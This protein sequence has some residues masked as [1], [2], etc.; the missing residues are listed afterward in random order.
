M[1]IARN[2]DSES[3]PSGATRLSFTIGATPSTK[4]TASSTPGQPTR[5]RGAAQSSS[6]PATAR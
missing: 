4:P 1:L 5:S 2:T 3:C 6:N